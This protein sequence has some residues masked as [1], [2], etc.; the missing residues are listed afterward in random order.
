[1]KHVIIVLSAVMFLVGCQT[2]KP[3]T[4]DDVDHLDSWSQIEDVEDGKVFVY[5]YSTYCH[6]CQL[7][8]EDVLSYAAADPDVPIYFM[9]T[10]DSR[11]QGSPPTSITSVPSL[12]V[13]EDHVF[14]RIVTGPQSVV[15]HLQAS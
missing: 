3:L 11:F 14:Q 7:I 4:Y 6:A 12:L 5:Y 10:Q 15:D 13:F 9:D 2:T 8:S 1:M